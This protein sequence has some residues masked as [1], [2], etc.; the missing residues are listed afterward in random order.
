MSTPKML[1]MKTTLK[2][3]MLS[4]QETSKGK[5]NANQKKVVFLES[6]KNMVGP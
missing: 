3:A 6:L 5:D 2:K 4:K 1:R